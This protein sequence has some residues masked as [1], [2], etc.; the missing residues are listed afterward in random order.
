MRNFRELDVWKLGIG[1][2]KK[3]YQLT[4]SLPEEEKYGLI[5]QMRRAS[6]SIPSNVAEG[7]SRSSNKEFIR[8][9]EISLG[10]SFELET[11]LLLVGDL[12]EIEVESSISELHEVQAKLNAFRTSVSKF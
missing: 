7:C 1:L 3:V 9:L 12:F 5:S 8:Y 11:L 6:V 4:A 2:P 10:S